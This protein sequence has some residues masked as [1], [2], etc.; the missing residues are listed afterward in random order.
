M[1]FG[2]LEE[3]RHSQ[4]TFTCSKLTIEALKQGVKYVQNEQKR[5]QNK[6]NNVVLLSLLL[7]LNMQLPTGFR[8]INLYS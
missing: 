7:T 3:K 4:T 6:A 5:H 8:Y 2:N 1:C